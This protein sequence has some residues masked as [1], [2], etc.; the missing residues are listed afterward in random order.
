MSATLTAPVS[1]RAATAAVILLSAL[2]PACRANPVAADSAVTNP[3]T[4]DVSG[5]AD[6]G[7]AAEAGWAAYLQVAD[8]ADD[9]IGTG[10]YDY[11]EPAWYI[12]GGA[13]ITFP[14]DLEFDA[15][16]QDVVVVDPD[17]EPTTVTQDVIVDQTL[18][19][20][21]GLFGAVGYS[22]NAGSR[23]SPRLEAEYQ[24]LLA[25]FR[26][27]NDQGMTWN[28]VGLNALIDLRLREHIKVYGGVGAGGVYA[29]FFTPGL[30]SDD[31]FSYYV[32]GLGG[33]L[34]RFSEDIDVDLGIR[35]TYS[36]LGLYDGDTDFDNIV[37]HLGLL[38]HLE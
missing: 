7:D 8:P 15:G 27:T 22:F 1:C 12:R 16:E 17:G 20:G 18:G 36:Q 6:L 26:G 9:E 3:A 19:W 13:M 32:Q 11:R 29:S 34:F 38:L 28:S 5:L 14:T 37:F 30:G 31:N 24:L 33:F 23:I 4:A 25:D 21:G 35:Y 10:A 2:A